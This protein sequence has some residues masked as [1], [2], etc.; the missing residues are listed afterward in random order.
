[1]ILIHP[2]FPD[3]VDRLLESGIA[4]KGDGYKINQ[5]YQTPVDEKFNE[6]AKEGSRLYNFL[7]ENASCFYV[8]RLQG[9]TFYSKYDFSKDL[10]DLYAKKTNVAFLGMQLHELGNTRGQDWHRILRCLAADGLSWTA[11]NIYESVKNISANKEYPHFSQGPATEYAALTPPRTLSEF[12]ADLDYVISARQKSTYGNV[13]KCDCAYMYCRSED[14]YNVNVSFIEVGG[15]HPHARIQFALRRGLSRK[16]GKKWGTYIEPW[17]GKRQTGNKH[18]WSANE[19]TAYQYT[20]DGSNDWH[21]SKDI[22]PEKLL[23]SSAGE[24]GG[25]SI[26]LAGRLMFYALF[27]GSNYFAEEWGAANTF[28]SWKEGGLTPYGLCKKRMADLS[29]R[30]T[31]VTAV[32]P[33]A[34]VLPKEYALVLTSGNDISFENDV[35]DGAYPDIIH[36]ISRLF[37]NGSTLG[38]EDDLLTTGRY[39]SI[40][41]IIYEDTYTN[42]EQEYEFLVDFSGKFAGRTTNAVDAYQEDALYTQLDAFVANYLPFTYKSSGDIDYMLFKNDGDNFCCILNHNG[43]SKSLEDGESVNPEASITVDIK[44]KDSSILEILNLCNHEYCHSSTNSLNTVL[45]GGD[46]ILFRYA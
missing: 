25:T 28:Y 44:M 11:E 17:G 15:Q 7:R 26:S 12:V 16:S 45:Q 21:I 36:R 8:D 10:I 29:R 2:Y 24:N 1:M 14:K 40:F 4:Q 23:F 20:K 34:I 38:G 9:G 5:T 13:L 31:N 43:I 27:S 32:A 35:I 33:I 19:L 6:I 18:T 3:Y 46:F 22:N 37:Y 42:P 30:L 41:D 39:G